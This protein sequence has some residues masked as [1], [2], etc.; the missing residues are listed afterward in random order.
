MVCVPRTLT[1]KT[2][3]MWYNR[4]TVNEGMPCRTRS[5]IKPGTGPVSFSPSD[6]RERPQNGVRGDISFGSVIRCM[7]HPYGESGA[8]NNFIPLFVLIQKVE[9][10]NQG[11]TKA[12]RIWFGTGR[13]VC[14]ACAPF[15]GLRS[16]MYFD[17]GD[18]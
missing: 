11:Q 1:I 16:E 17:I 4:M 14:P 18:E 13:S 6:I 15:A 12:S 2:D 7:P 9:Q 5:R 3:V 8:E 10:K